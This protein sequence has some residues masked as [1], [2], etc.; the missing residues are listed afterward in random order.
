MCNCH[1]CFDMQRKI[2]L[3]VNFNNTSNIN[4]MPVLNVNSWILLA[5]LISTFFVEYT[6]Q[7]GDNCRLQNAVHAIC[8]G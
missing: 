7:N 2:K 6:R 1:Y 8:L 3:A 4:T 5:L